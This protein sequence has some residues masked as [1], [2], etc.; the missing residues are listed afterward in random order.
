VREAWSPTRIDIATHAQFGLDLKGAHAA[1]P[2][3][4]CHKGFGQTTKGST[5]RNATSSRRL[6][7]AQRVRDCKDCHAK[8][9][10]GSR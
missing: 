4:E 3:V 5:L 7:F 1:L 6:P 2:C 9:P 10:G 8:L